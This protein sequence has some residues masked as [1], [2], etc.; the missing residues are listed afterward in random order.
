MTLLVRTWPARH[1]SIN[2][3]QKPLPALEFNGA[4]T[5]LPN[6]STP[7]REAGWQGW[8]GRQQ[9]RGRRAESSTMLLRMTWRHFFFYLLLEHS[10]WQRHVLGFIHLAVSNR[11]PGG[12][13]LASIHIECFAHSIPHPCRVSKHLTRPEP[14]R[15]EPRRSGE[16]V[17]GFPLTTAP[18]TDLKFLLVFPEEATMAGQRIDLILRLS[19]LGSSQI[20][21]TYSLPVIRL[22]AQALA[23]T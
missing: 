20:A 10:Q 6:L 18:G 7:G 11:N 23:T 2:Q 16:R 8:R 5:R 17:G 12:E 21:P 19:I 22:G 15:T 3:Y 1:S 9:S 13:W 14:T 4:S